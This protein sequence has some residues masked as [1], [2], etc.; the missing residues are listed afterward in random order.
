MVSAFW[1]W[2]NFK[3]TPRCNAAPKAPMVLSW[4]HTFS[5]VR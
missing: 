1:H 4:M 2:N 3:A 5:S